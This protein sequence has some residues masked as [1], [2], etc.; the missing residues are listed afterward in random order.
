MDFTTGENSPT[1]EQ[2]GM[3]LDP[4]TGSV[5]LSTQLTLPDRPLVTIE[6]G[7]TWAAVSFR[8]LWSYRELFYFL[9]W[10]DIKVR[11]KQTIVGFTWVVVQ[12]LFQTLVFTIFF[13]MLAGLPSDGIPYPVFAFAG[14]LPWTFFTRAVGSSGNSLVGSSNLITK[15]YFPRIIIP[16]ASVL[17]GLVDSAI[18]FCVLLGLMAYYHVSLTWAILMLP[19]LV[20]L[21]TLFALGI[22]MWLSAI[23][24]KYRDVGQILPL[25][26]QF[27]MYASPVLYA[28]SLIPAKWHWVMVINPMTGFLEGFRAAILGR[29]AFNWKALALSTVVTLAVLIYSSYA[30]KRMER[31]FADIV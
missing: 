22:G 12:P 13:G 7:R 1:L 4:S 26:L 17:S 10:R 29:T 20:V 8:E 14:L 27:W 5:A 11:Y 3:T 25:V 30:F 16:G 24:V 23:N 31:T 6:P 9:I 28:S 19:F 2:L 18:S 15:V 21:L